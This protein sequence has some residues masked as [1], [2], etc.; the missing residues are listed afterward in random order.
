[1]NEND[2]QTIIIQAFF[3]AC[4]YLQYNPPAELRTEEEAK[5]CIGSATY[6]NGWRQWANYFINEVLK[7]KEIENGTN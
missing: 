7:E 1:M 6:K 4:Q 3:K 2:S 5:A